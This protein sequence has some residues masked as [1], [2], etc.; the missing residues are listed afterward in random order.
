[1]KPNS[2]TTTP[3]RSE[4]IYFLY[5]SQTGNSEQ[6]ALDLCNDAVEKLS[7]FCIEP[8]HMQ[9]DDFLE[10]QECKWTRLVV[11]V[12]SSYGVGQAP[13]GSWRFRELCDAWL[14][15]KHEQETK[16]LDGV[17]YALC[18]L[19]DSKYTTFFKNPTVIDHGLT[20]VGAQRVGPLGK[21]DASGKSQAAQSRVIDEWSR[22]IWTHLEQVLQ[23]EPVS[24]E[25]LEKMQQDTVQAIRKID[26]DFLRSESAASKKGA[27][28]SPMSLKLIIIGIAGALLAAVIHY[29]VQVQNQSSK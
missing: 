26:P 8:I 12:V 19:G 16:L 2:T 4:R 29:Y 22:N 20:S 3:P 10:L 6:A 7:K 11:I 25:R 27:S 13:L 28:S 17:Q 24:N 18:G 23:Q 1:M 5:G 9:L 14:E 15:Q 21:A